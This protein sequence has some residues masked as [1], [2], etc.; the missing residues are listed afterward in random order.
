[1][2]ITALLQ[3]GTLR[4]ASLP[5]ANRRVEE[6]DAP[7]TVPLLAEDYPAK[8]AAMWNA[9]YERLR[10]PDRNMMVIANPIDLPE[11]MQAFRDDPRYR[12]GGAGVGFKEAVVQ[13]LD[14]VTPLA[15]AMG[16]V[17]IIKKEDGRLIGDN[18]DGAGYASSLEE[19]FLARGGSLRGAHIL[20]L[21]A[22]GSGRAISFALADKGAQLSI[23]NRTKEKAEELAGMLNHY[24]ASD[25]AFGGGRGELSSL[26][27]TAD[28]V[29]SVID[30]AA[31]P[32][33]AYSTIGDMTLP[34][35]QASVEQNRVSAEELLRHAKRS[36]IVSDIRIR[37]GPTAMLAQAASLGFK[38]LDGIPMVVN[39]G[40]DAFWWLYQNILVAKGITKKDVAQIMHTAAWA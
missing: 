14:E 26:F 22:G 24:F 4:V 33:D 13:Y 15:K 29:V 32:L 7:Y 17:N 18:T 40:V 16:A 5:P 8:T 39:Q 34:I 27:G 31:S 3:K 30:D 2:N 35:T 23:L 1:M 11:I 19:L 21:G 20:V 9:M 6:G 28:A 37:K 38:T 12:G 36:L 25:I 10:V